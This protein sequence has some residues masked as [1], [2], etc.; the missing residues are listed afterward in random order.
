[1]RLGATEKGE[2]TSPETSS[3]QLCEVPGLTRELVCRD[4]VFWPLCPAAGTAAPLPCKVPGCVLREGEV[5][6]MWWGLLEHCSENI[7]GRYLAIDA[8]LSA[9]GSQ[10]LLVVHLYWHLSGRFTSRRTEQIVAPFS[11]VTQS[12]GP[13]AAPRKP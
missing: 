5:P 1:M 7:Q 10:E 4:D 6:G 3:E 8:I 12:W 9:L 11:L 2:T 13:S